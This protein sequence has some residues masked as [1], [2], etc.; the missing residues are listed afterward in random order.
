[1]ISSITHSLTDMEQTRVTTVHR[2]KVSSGV[3]E[4]VA[5]LDD[6]SWVVRRTVVESLASLGE[7]AIEAICDTLTFHRDSEARIAAAVDTLVAMKTSVEAA[8]FQLAKHTDPAIVADAAQILG[9]RRHLPSIPILVQLTQHV[10]DNVAVAAIE[11]LGRIGG[12]AAVEA[13][14]QAAGSGN[15]FRTFPAI[16]VLGRSGDP[17]AIEPLVKLLGNPSYRPEAARALGRSGERAALRPLI[18]LLKSA[19]DSTVRMAAVSLWDLREHFQEKSGGKSVLVD[20]ILRN[21][22]DPEAVRRISRVLS[23]ADVIEGVIICKLLGTIGNSEAMVFLTASLDSSAQVAAS[24]ASALK[25]IGKDAE[26]GF[27]RAIAEGSSAR[28]KALLPIVTRFAAAREVAQCLTDPDADV[29]ALACETLGRLG[30]P[31]VVRE[32]FPLLADSNLRVGHA[33]TAAIQ[34]LGSRQARELAVETFKS[35]DP[36]VRRSALRILAYF[37]DTE[38][39]TPMLEGLADDDVRVREVALQGLPY[40]ES[41]EA[42][43]ALFEATK[44]ASAKTRALAMRALGQIPKTSER[45]LARLLGGLF[46]A[47]AWVRYYACQSLGRLKY[48][49]ASKELSVML[50]DDAGQVRVAAVEALSHIDSIEA[51]QILRQ[52]ASSTEIEIK[53]AALVGLGIAHRIED[54]PIVLAAVRDSDMPTRLMALSALVS[55]SS[56]LVVGALSS[57]TAD[58]D[59]QVRSTAIQFLAGRPEQDATEVLVD[60]LGTELNRELAKAA[61]LVPAAGRVAGLLIVLESASDEMAPRLISILSRI[62]RPEARAALLSAMKLKNVAARKAAASGLSARQDREMTAALSDASDNDSDPD[63]RQICSLLLRD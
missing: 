51:R 21:Q 14:I 29:R 22:I 46:D 58:E 31:S 4:L 27:V 48:S 47:D 57:A 28:R 56:P 15:F 50:D 6:S 42:F 3:R 36:I 2:L 35:N 62:E 43:E 52:A 54:L 19:S 11:A 10:D 39:L 12:R 61:L 34:A 17:R 49:A 13:L 60:L 63:V 59:E 18:E 38:S 40:L 25:K 1:M 33:A 9:R 8:V 41:P 24:A 53:R 37:G 45:T 20:E 44:S 23:T 32:V 7:T 5:M 26:E 30:N 16:D 55:F